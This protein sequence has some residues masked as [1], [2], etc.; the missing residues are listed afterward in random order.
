MERARERNQ[1]TYN[2]RYY[3]HNILKRLKSL[4]KEEAFTN[5]EKSFIK[6]VISK[7]QVGDM[8]AT[9][10]RRVKNALEQQADPHKALYII[11]NEFDEEF[12]LK[13]RMTKNESSSLKKSE[14]ILSKYSIKK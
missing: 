5:H 6:L 9:S 13:K 10:I 3:M 2:N 8:T 14:V 1:K 11:K 4:K 7:Y 12:L